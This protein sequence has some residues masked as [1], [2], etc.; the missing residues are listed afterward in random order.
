MFGM[1]A[2]IGKSKACSSSIP[3]LFTGILEV[4]LCSGYMQCGFRTG[5]PG[6]T[7]EQLKTQNLGPHPRIRIRICRY[8]VCTFKLEKYCITQK[9]FLLTERVLKNSDKSVQDSVVIGDY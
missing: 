6:L 7:R 5:N 2:F 4:I 1:S 3:R 9:S 8:S